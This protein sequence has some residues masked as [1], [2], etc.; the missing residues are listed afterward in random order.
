MRMAFKDSYICTFTPHVMNYFGKVWPV[1]KCK[2][3]LDGGCTG[4]SL[5]FSDA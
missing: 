4:V 5:S 3:L 2:V 1:G